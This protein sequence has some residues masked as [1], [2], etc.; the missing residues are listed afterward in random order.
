[1]NRDIR[2][3]RAATL[4]DALE[5]AY[6]ELGT[7]ATILHTRQIEHRSW[8]PFGRT[9]SEVEIT[10]TSQPQQVATKPRINPPKPRSSATRATPRPLD[11]TLASPPP[12][13][14]VGPS[15]ARSL[16][17]ELKKR[18]SGPLSH[19]SS[20]AVGSPRPGTSTP[21]VRSTGNGRGMGH[22][23]EKPNTKVTP[24]PQANHQPP[25]TTGSV[26]NPSSQ[27]DSA[28][29][30]RRNPLPTRVTPPS[31][32]PALTPAPRG[33]GRWQPRQ[34]FEQS[35]VD[36]NPGETNPAARDQQQD[37][38]SPAKDVRRSAPES[39]VSTTPSSLA[40]G[41]DLPAKPVSLLPAYEPSGLTLPGARI[42]K[43][44]VLTTAD[45]VHDSQWWQIDQRLHENQQSLEQFKTSSMNR[46]HETREVESTSWQEM[47]NQTGLPENIA[48]KL[49]KKL[50]C[51]ATPKEL[52]DPQAS[53]LLLL[54]LIEQELNL[55]RP[56]QIAPG[57]PQ[58]VA[59][60]GPTGVGKTTTLAK[61]AAQARLREHRKVGLITVDT[62]RI[63][64]VEQ[65]KTYAEIMEL[66][67][68]VVSSPA[69]MRSAMDDYATMDLVLIDT[70]GRSP[71]DELKNQELKAIL[72][73]A[74]A[75][76][77]HLCISMASDPRSITMIA[78][79]FI[80]I[81]ANQLI[82]TKLDEI[83]EYGA[84]LATNINSTLPLSYLTTG[85]EVPDHLERAAASRLAR[86]I[87][88]AEPLRP[89]ILATS[90][91]TTTNAFASPV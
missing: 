18:T 66:P 46:F 73:E 41:V 3:Y 38:S 68:R 63:A 22:Q 35:G 40:S 59:L 6:R 16:E 7:E 31:N 44:A 43:P 27:L 62:F 29:T 33:L 72:A 10:A 21:D 58:I 64:A 47:V 17:A 23:P 28:T 5:Q 8:L 91:I 50:A 45:A 56:V 2:V 4:D 86:L 20:P 14:G 84:V 83:Q 70:S 51:L 88:S 69:E 89:S 39:T 37:Q 34:S 79:K 90:S 11:E 42:E 49:L 78:S 12:L 61:L 71:Y 60:V 82:L 9:S 54:S 53:R 65:L 77:I 87:L 76:E 74:H 15:A 13:L 67:M 52:T 1:M 85:Q 75:H 48:R 57:T 26:Q 32:S 30:P 36:P 55:S 25:A 19:P 81:G 24:Q 80:T